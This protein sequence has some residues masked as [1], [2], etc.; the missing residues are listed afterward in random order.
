MKE[1]EGPVY[2]D[3]SVSLPP[4]YFCMNR[5]AGDPVD[6]CRIAVWGF[7]DH[8][9][10]DLTCYD[11]GDFVSQAV[12]GYDVI[13]ALRRPCGL[14]IT[15]ENWL[16]MPR[17]PV[18][19]IIDG[20]TDGNQL[21][22]AHVHHNVEYTTISLYD[23]ELKTF[24]V[25]EKQNG[26]AFLCLNADYMAWFKFVRILWSLTCS[27]LLPCRFMFQQCNMQK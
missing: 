13:D 11:G 5:T 23:D 22:T 15:G 14:F 20:V 21:R 25:S 9:D 26:F 3:I 27:V 17:I 8:V 24:D 19:A 2:I 7:V 4:E 10:E 18:H 1:G 6:V 12:F 16:E